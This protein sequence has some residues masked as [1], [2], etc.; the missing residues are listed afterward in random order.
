MRTLP[1]QTCPAKWDS[2]P[3]QA[4]H[5]HTHACRV[6]RPREA[7]ER[8]EGF[9]VRDSTATA[10]PT[11]VT[12]LPDREEGSTQRPADHDPC[13]SIVQYTTSSIRREYNT[14][15]VLQQY[16]LYGNRGTCRQTQPTTSAILL[17][18]REVRGRGLTHSVRTHTHTRSR[19]FYQAWFP[20]SVAPNSVYTHTHTQAQ[21]ADAP[22]AR[23][24]RTARGVNCRT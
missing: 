11:G 10:P 7:V 13:W 17:L 6:Q 18:K 5:T 15:S 9:P 8:T 24:G 23:P 14:G 1:R 16:Y 21:G 19:S 12:A 22:S 2:A 3:S 20:N 4:A